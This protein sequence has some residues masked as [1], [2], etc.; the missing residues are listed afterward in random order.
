MHVADS[1]ATLRLVPGGTLAQQR[2]GNTSPALRSTGSAPLRQ[3]RLQSFPSPVQTP[4]SS[5]LG[6]IVIRERGRLRLV[7]HHS[8]CAAP[9]VIRHVDQAE[10]RAGQRGPEVGRMP[11]LLRRACLLF[12]FQSAFETVASWKNVLETT[13]LPVLD[14]LKLSA[15]PAADRFL[16]LQNK[17]TSIAEARSPSTRRFPSLAARA[18]VR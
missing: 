7:Q 16:P 11:T 5:T 2:S 9:L 10:R 15:T 14:C 12:F 18:E 6:K 3:S 4:Q 8:A 17:D 13:T 1:V